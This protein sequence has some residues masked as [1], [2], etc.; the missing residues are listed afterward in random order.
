MLLKKIYDKSLSLFLP[1][2]LTYKRV[3][4]E[5]GFLTILFFTIYYTLLGFMIDTT[6]LISFTLFISVLIRIKL[7]D[8]KWDSE[9]KN[10]PK[11][12]KL[13][14]VTIII[15]GGFFAYESIVF[16]DGEYPSLSFIPQVFYILYWVHIWSFLNKNEEPTYYVN[17][18]DDNST[19][20]K[21]AST[22]Y[23]KGRTY[24]NEDKDLRAIYNFK[25][26]VYKYN[27]L[28]D[29]YPSTTKENEIAKSYSN[30]ASCFKDA[31][32][33][34]EEKVKQRKNRMENGLDWEE[35]A[36][37]QAETRTC[38]SCNKTYRLSEMI[39]VD[40][41][42][43]SRA[44]YCTS[45]Y[46]KKKKKARQRY[47]KNRQ[48]TKRKHKNKK[49]KKQREANNKSSNNKSSNNK[50]SKYNEK[51][52]KR[53]RR[54]RR[55][56]QNKNNRSSKSSNNKSSDNK[57]RVNKSNN[58]MLKSEAL[59]ILNCDENSSQD[60]IKSSYRKLVKKHHPDQGGD[61]E[62]FKKVK[63]AYETLSR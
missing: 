38:D 9:I 7:A 21:S 56:K 17:P 46:K 36:K 40:E 5:S 61:T 53:E 48:K 49:K 37:E 45:C 3:L 60:E 22:S 26:A 29:V 63:K 28:K 62:K 55:K 23:E 2:N 16:Y 32:L 58:G 47:N 43:Y 24:L 50:S 6:I 19:L 34:S 33:I 8:C 39:W 27:K 1:R 20:W 18:N 14:I 30:A 15:L 4:I 54:K 44:K 31:A 11:L 41:G 13:G 51:R 42:E 52:R 59:E 35:K 25:Q 12:I 57:Q 10:D